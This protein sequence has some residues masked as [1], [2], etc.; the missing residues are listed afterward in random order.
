[1]QV[2][3]WEFAAGPFHNRFAQLFCLPLVA[4]GAALIPRQ[5]FAAYR[6]GLA[7]RSLFTRE[8]GFAVRDLPVA[9]LVA[10]TERS[11]DPVGFR[12]EVTG[13]CTLVSASLSMYVLPIL[14]LWSCLR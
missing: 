5:Q 4:L 9:D 6:D 1:M 2:A 7:R 14:L 12:R 10:M 8:P 3:T 11:H 13:Y